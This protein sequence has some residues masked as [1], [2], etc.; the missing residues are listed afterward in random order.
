MGRLIY[1]DLLA[2][3]LRDAYDY[4]IIRGLDDDWSRGMCYGLD[5]S[6]RRLADAP[7]VEVPDIVRCCD[8]KSWHDGECEHDRINNNPYAYCSYGVRRQE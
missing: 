4:N 7:E 1:A 5:F 6:I 2:V 8:C 3:R